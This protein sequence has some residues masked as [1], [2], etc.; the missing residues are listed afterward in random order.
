MNQW[1]QFSVSTPAQKAVADM[2][3]T[4]K[5]PYTCTHTGVHYTTYYE[6]LLSMY[7]T[8]LNKLVAAVKESGLIPIK[9]EGSFFLM[10]DTS[11]IKMP[12]AYE[13]LCDVSIHGKSSADIAWSLLIT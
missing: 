3:Q 4:A 6:Y 8:K 9:P 2:F 1:V 10:C 7:E 11:N 12:P 13:S 5:L